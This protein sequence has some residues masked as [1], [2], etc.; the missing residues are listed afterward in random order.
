MESVND[1]VLKALAPFANH[2]VGSFVIADS[3]V[4]ECL[5]WGVGVQVMLEKFKISGISL[6]GCD[7]VGV[8]PYRVLQKQS[9]GGNIQK[10]KKLFF[11]LSW[12]AENEENVLEHAEYDAIEEI[13]SRYKKQKIQISNSFAE[14]INEFLSTSSWLF[15]QIFIGFCWPSKIYQS[16]FSDGAIDTMSEETYIDSFSYFKDLIVKFASSLNEGKELESKNSRESDEKKSKTSYIERSNQNPVNVLVEHVPIYFSPIFENFLLVPA[17]SGIDFLNVRLAPNLIES[18]IP[19]VFDSLDID[20]EYYT[21]G[22]QGNAESFLRR[23][24]KHEQVLEKK[25]KKGA[26]NF[27]PVFAS[28]SSSNSSVT[29]SVLLYDRNIDLLSLMAHSDHILDRVY[30]SLMLDNGNNND[31]ISKEFDDIFPSFIEPGSASGSVGGCLAHPGDL[32]SLA[33]FK[34]L[35]EANNRKIMKSIDDILGENSSLR[36][37][38]FGIEQVQHIEQSLK[39][40]LCGPDPHTFMSKLGTAEILVGIVEGLR[41]TTFWDEIANFEKLLRLSH[42]NPGVYGIE[43]A[44]L[45]SQL[46]ALIRSH[47]PQRVDLQTALCLTVYCYALKSLTPFEKTNS[48]SPGKDFPKEDRKQFI[49]FMTRAFGSSLLSWFESNTTFLATDGEETSDCMLILNCFLNEVNE[50]MSQMRS[51]QEL[52]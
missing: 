35:V 26:S 22:G 30:H 23:R 42:A 50:L 47:A 12:N 24:I 46:N 37:S 38:S 17:L 28:S 32:N 31:V 9:L 11:L 10:S 18:Y 29:A 27:F 14:K 15:H 40:I 48:I 21:F 33:T 5:H 34:D 41:R 7:D 44:S 52:K 39:K 43:E 20:P 51:L 19:S 3:V 16:V 36:I 13:D 2:L 49:D 8:D 4:M 45:L 1:Q 6:L 25:A